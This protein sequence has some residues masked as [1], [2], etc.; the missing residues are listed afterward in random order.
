MLYSQEFL[1]RLPDCVFESENYEDLVATSN[2]VDQDERARQIKGYELSF[3]GKECHRQ[4]K[5][6][7]KV[8]MFSTPTFTQAT[9][10]AALLN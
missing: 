9:A 5:E 2:I 7:T 1:R 3:K 10:F 8:T 6:L 4:I